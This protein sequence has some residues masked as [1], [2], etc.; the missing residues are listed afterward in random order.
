MTV[1]HLLSKFKILE[2]YQL[3]HLC[4]V[5]HNRFISVRLAPQKQY[6]IMHAPN[7]ESLLINIFKKIN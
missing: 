4:L 3:V 6:E 5:K 1:S 2:S 7:L